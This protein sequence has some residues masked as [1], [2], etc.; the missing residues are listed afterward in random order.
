MNID[1]IIERDVDGRTG[2]SMVTSEEP[3]HGKAGNGLQHKLE[4]LREAESLWVTMSGPW[5]AHRLQECLKAGDF[6][7]AERVVTQ[8][9]ALIHGS[10]NCMYCDK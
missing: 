2:A 3:D 6:V 5:L 4:Q 10:R 7:E 8:A 9:L 1:A